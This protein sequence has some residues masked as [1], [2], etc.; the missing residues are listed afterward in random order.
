MQL[1]V[2]RRQ[3]QTTIKPS[4]KAAGYKSTTNVSRPPCAPPQTINSVW[5]NSQH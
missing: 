2:A 1:Q 5:P 4:L 3:Q